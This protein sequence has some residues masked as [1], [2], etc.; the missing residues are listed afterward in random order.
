MDAISVNVA[1][2][3]ILTQRDDLFEI[4][5]DTANI[6]MVSTDADFY[7]NEKKVTYK[8][9]IDWIISSAKPIKAEL[10]PDKRR[11]DLIIKAKLT[12]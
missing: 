8:E 9:L 10:H 7:T 12:K 1:N 6:F 2:V 4:E 3:I 11:Y 5:S